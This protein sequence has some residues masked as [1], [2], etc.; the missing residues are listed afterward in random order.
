MEITEERLM[1]VLGVEGGKEQEA[2]DP[3]PEEVYTL[4][5]GFEGSEPAEDPTRTVLSLDDAASK[6][7]VRASSLRC[8]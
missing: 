3:A 7:S 1:E 6:A 4:V 2:A 8:Q 5:A